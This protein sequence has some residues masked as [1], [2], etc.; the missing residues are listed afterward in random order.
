MNNQYLLTW[1]VHFSALDV[2][3]QFDDYFTIL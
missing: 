3:I 2:G 1:L